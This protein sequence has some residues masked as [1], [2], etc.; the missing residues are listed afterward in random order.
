M[1]RPE[2]LIATLGT[3]AQ[4]VTLSLLELERLGFDISEVV[5]VHTAVKTGKIRE[6][7]ERLDAVCR[8]G[9]GLG[10]K[11]CRR[12]TKKENACMATKTD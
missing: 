7:I 5:V 8:P 4:V 12:A 3:E 6:A 2:V 1:K 10:W 9:C 11:G